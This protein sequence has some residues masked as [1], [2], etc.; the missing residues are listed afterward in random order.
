[1]IE[2][3]PSIFVTFHTTAA[4][5]QTESLCRK[6]NIPG[7]LMPVPR[8]VTSDCGI[9][10]KTE[11]KYREQLERLIQDRQIEADQIHSL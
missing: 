2:K 10:W 11:P 9:G 4:A 3:K 8:S 7:R 5:M 6:E 1:V